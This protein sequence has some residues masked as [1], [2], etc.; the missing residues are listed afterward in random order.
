MHLRQAIPPQ[1]EKAVLLAELGDGY[2][3]PQLSIRRG[4]AP[5]EELVEPTF[6]F[7]EKLQNF[8]AKHVSP[9]GVPWIAFSLSL[10][11]HGFAFQTYQISEF[12]RRSQ[13]DVRAGIRASCFDS[14]TTDDS[15]HL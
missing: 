5:Q 13:R 2:A 14:P 1:A 11:K 12:G 9:T 4:S 8:W 7:A 15:V 3:I 6:E 10:D